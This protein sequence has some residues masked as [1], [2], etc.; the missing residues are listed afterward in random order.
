MQ[1]CKCKIAY[2]ERSLASPGSLRFAYERLDDAG[3]AEIQLILC[4]TCF[5]AA[6]SQR[7]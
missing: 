6:S 4:S 3:R 2:V 5:P 7:P 1:N